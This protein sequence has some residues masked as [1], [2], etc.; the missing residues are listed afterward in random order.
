MYGSRGLGKHLTSF[1]IWADAI[2]FRKNRVG[3]L[4]SSL[5]WIFLDLML[6]LLLTSPFKQPDPT[7]CPPPWCLCILQG[8]SP[9][10]FSLSVYIF[11]SFNLPLQ[12]RSYSPFIISVARIWNPSN[13]LTSFEKPGI[14]YNI[15]HV[16]WPE[17]MKS[18]TITSLLL[19]FLPSMP[20]RKLTS[21]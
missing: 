20:Q 5:C 19:L 1:T 4:F 21:T 17:A 14:Q 3:N 8:S 2:Q 7:F 16:I 9:T 6:L 10:T 12:M 15:L 13:L 11:S 18:R